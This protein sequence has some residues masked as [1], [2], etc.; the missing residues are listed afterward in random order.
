MTEQGVPRRRIYHIDGIRGILAMLVACSHF[1]GSITG[2]ASD[3][4]LVGA[5]LAVDFFFLGGVKHQ[6]QHRFIELRNWVD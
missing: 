4:P 1:Y 5:A 2:Y 3:R 6:V